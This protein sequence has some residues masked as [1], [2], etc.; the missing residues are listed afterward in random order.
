M[1]MLLRRFAAA[2][3]AILA[4]TFLAVGSSLV[5][6]RARQTL[7]GRSQVTVCADDWHTAAAS[8]GKAVQS[9]VR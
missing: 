3:T 1:R 7:T 9:L 8:L 4:L 6:A 2:M 5:S